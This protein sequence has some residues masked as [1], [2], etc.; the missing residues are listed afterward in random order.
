MVAQ[1]GQQRFGFWDKDIHFVSTYD[2][3]KNYRVLVEVIVS[4]CIALLTFCNC[5][6]RQPLPVWRP[7]VP[8]CRQGL[9]QCSPW[10]CF[11]IVLALCR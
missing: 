3:F 8:V 6:A 10:T 2:Y 7:C 9:L 4:V 11:V 1:V 5:A